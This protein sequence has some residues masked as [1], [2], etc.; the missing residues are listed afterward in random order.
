MTWARS[1]NGVAVG[2]HALVIGGGAPS[3]ANDVSGGVLNTG[4]AVQSGDVFTLSYAFDP[5]AGWAAEEGLDVILFTS[6]DNTIGGAKTLLWSSL[7]QHN[8]AGDLTYY[9]Y[10]TSAITIDGGSAHVGQSLFIEFN[11]TTTAGNIDA[12]NGFA[13]VDDVQLSVVPEP[14]T[15]SLLA[16]GGIALIRRRRK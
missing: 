6:D 4:Y 2:T 10:D 7:S 9:N 8:A 5:L 15:M 14:A 3:P 11:G 13:R 1:N 12:F 16:I